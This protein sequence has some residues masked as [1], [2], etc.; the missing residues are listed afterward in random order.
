MRLFLAFHLSD[1]VRAA[2]A[3]VQERLKASGAEARWSP[4][5]QFHL[6]VKFLGD[7]DDSLLPDIE[8]YSEWLAGENS[9]FRFRMRGVSVFP[10]R[11]PDIRTLWVGLSEG[12]E[13]W[14]A[15]AGQAQEA[16]A[17]FGVPVEQDLVPHITLG[18]VKKADGLDG[19][20]AAIAAE[21]QTD[22]GEQAAD[23]LTTIS[24]DLKVRIEALNDE[25]K[26]VSVLLAGQQ[27]AGALAMR[28]EPRPDAR[29]GLQALKDLGIQTVMLTGDNSRTA[30]AIGAQLGM[31]D[32]RAELLP[33][34]K[35]RIVGELRAKGMTVAKVGDGIN[36]APALAAA[37]IGIAMG[38]GTDV[39][40]ETADAAVLRGRIGDIA[41]MVRL[42]K[43]TMTNIKQNITIALGLKA[44]FL[45]T[46]VIGVTGLWPA[47]LADTGAT[48]LVTM[49][50]LRLLSPKLDRDAV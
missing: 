26:T 38:G 23:E 9:A 36:D 22:C 42:S 50:A 47:I 49:N 39:A 14:K 3:E 10:K 17:P 6:T 37:D 19:L 12:A 8:Y 27:V 18:R 43:N 2:V 30:Q 4:P 15:I 45:V 35:Q 1:E 32:V 29:D 16:F 33:D 41:R 5:E 20:R 34:E 40:L 28:D 31:D 24:A 25:G 7:L 21:A 44:V 46:T 48:V 13:G 11:G